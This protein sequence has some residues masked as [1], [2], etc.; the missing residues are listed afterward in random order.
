[1]NQSF[2]RYENSQGFRS[3]KDAIAELKARITTSKV[4]QNLEKEKQTKQ[5][6]ETHQQSVFKSYSNIIRPD[7][8][9]IAAQ[10][11]K[12]SQTNFQI[13]TGEAPS[14]KSTTVVSHPAKYVKHFDKDFRLRETDKNNRTNFSFDLKNRQVIN[15]LIPSKGQLD[16]ELANQTRMYL[17]QSHIQLGTGHNKVHNYLTSHLIG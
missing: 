17:K 5:T 15:G 1:M 9:I 7:N 10:K 11:E 14:Y 2:G 16:Q 12:L 13:G 3:L 6:Y 4:M 8:S